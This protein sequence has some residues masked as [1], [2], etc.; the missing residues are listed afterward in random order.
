MYIHGMKTAITHR[1]IG[2]KDRNI[3]ALRFK[4][5]QATAAQI[6]LKDDKLA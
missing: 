6:N 2:S 5:R 1:F 3:D 4:Q